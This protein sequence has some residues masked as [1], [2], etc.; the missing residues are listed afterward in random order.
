L[1]EK[2]KKSTFFGGPVGKKEGTSVEGK[3]RS[4]DGE[5]RP[6]PEMEWGTE[7]KSD[8]A[9]PKK[10]KEIHL[11]SGVDQRRESA[12]VRPNLGGG[13]KGFWVLG[14]RREHPQPQPTGLKNFGKIFSVATFMMT[15]DGDGEK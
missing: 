11:R 14:K 3:L 9:S 13:G 6:S 10:G 5:Y 8:I 7:K 4:G 12:R 2:R 1:V 15:S